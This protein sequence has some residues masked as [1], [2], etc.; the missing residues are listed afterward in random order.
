MPR[1]RPNNVAHAAITSHRIALPSTERASAKPIAGEL[2]AWR[3]PPPSLASRNLG[4]ALFQLGGASKNWEQVYRA[5]QLLSHLPQRD[6]QVLATL[7]SILL[8]QNHPE[9]AVSLY[10]Q[11]LALEP[12]NARF[13]YVLGAA[14]NAQGNQQAAIAEL[15]HSIE[16]DPSAPDPYRKLGEIYDR[17]GFPS[18]S[19][20]SLADYLKFMPQNITF[21]RR[22]VD[23]PSAGR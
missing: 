12:R 17:L 4:L 19:R 10:R 7:G 16:L 2:T 14:L 11:A 5:Y 8:E 9:L 21:R 1:V 22:V 18:L 15:R 6:P 20:Q 23:A 13:S 3:D